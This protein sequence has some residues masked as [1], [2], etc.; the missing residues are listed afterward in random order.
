MSPG[1]VTDSSF[2]E[3][4]KKATRLISN[5]QIKIPNRDAV[6][7]KVT[8]VCGHQFLA[9]SLKEPTCC[10]QCQ[11][12]IWFT[13]QSCKL[14]KLVCHSRCL[15]QITYSCSNAEGCEGR[16]A[17]GFHKFKDHYFL[18]PTFCNHCG[19][20]LTGIIEKQ[21]LEC[22]PNL[23]G[24]GMN[25]HRDCKML[26]C[27]PCHRNSASTGDLVKFDVHQQ[28]SDVSD[29]CS[30]SRVSIQDFDLIGLIGQGSFSKVYLARL[31]TDDSKFAIKVTKKT[32]LEVNSDPESVFSEMR[33]FE[34]SRQYPFI[35]TAHCCF[36][37]EARLFVVM[38]YI[39][40]RDLAYY[41]YQLGQEFSEDRARFHCAEV[42]LALRFLHRQGVVHRDVKLENII[43]DQHG[44]CKILDFSMSKELNRCDYLRT[45]TF[46]GS[47]P[48]VSPEMIK[49]CEYGFSIDWWAFG[50]MV[51]EMLLGEPPFGDRGEL[52]KRI[53]EDDLH[54]PM[55]G[56]NL[57]KE[58]KSIIEGFLTKNPQIRLGCNIHDNYEFAILKH[59]FFLFK[60]P[61]ASASSF[62]WDQI[63]R[64]ELQPPY[65]P[66]LD[67]PV[68]MLN[69]SESELSL[70][71]L[72]AR[73]LDG[74]CQK[75][76]DKFSYYSESFESHIQA[77][78]LLSL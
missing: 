56:K 1:K 59:P 3:G 5:L 29:S 51:Y 25:V 39:Q 8:N 70:T 52:Y 6:R 24:C 50:V 28:S 18:T 7:Y 2:S 74:V 57:S 78:Q 58:A 20:L 44:H 32:T 45:A 43:L 67:R 49:K 14:C 22:D 53:I 37:D 23:D 27:R 66:K 26:V 15:H 41:I 71:P 76:F 62:Q 72:S 31:R 63:E 77:K 21:G 35:A 12:L 75:D 11:D 42:V 60:P 46:C 38:E 17:H 9:V 19:T 69:C 48:Y 64:M 61:S 30:L 34:Q 16:F 36:Q 40:G 54:F 4:L 73:Q 47:P 65:I 68:N 33:V 13:G 55:R 10:S